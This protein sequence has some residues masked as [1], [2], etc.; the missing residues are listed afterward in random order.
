MVRQRRKGNLQN[1]Q[2]GQDTGRGG[3]GSESS[4]SKKGVTGGY[5]PKSLPFKKGSGAGPSRKRK[6]DLLG[7]AQS[8]PRKSRKFQERAQPPME[9]DEKTLLL[10]QKLP[11]KE[12]MPQLPAQ[13]LSSPK[14]TLHNALQGV[15][16]PK[17]TIELQSSG[18]CKCDVFLHFPEM[19][20]IEA[21]GEGLN[22]KSAEKAAYLHLLCKLNEQNLL[23][24]IWPVDEKVKKDTMNEEKDAK[25]DVYIYAA[26]YGLVPKFSVKSISILRRGHGKV[27]EVTINL[28][29]QGIS[30]VGRSRSE[31]MAEVAASMKFKSAAE[32]YLSES[33]KLSS[34]DEN[35]VLNVG[36]AKSFFLWYKQEFPASKHTV[37]HSQSSRS[38]QQAQF[39]LQGEKIGEP[40]TM[41]SKKLAEEVATLVAAI[42]VTKDSPELRARFFDVFRRSNNQIL[43]PLPPSDMPVSSQTLTKMRATLAEARRSG[44]GDQY[45]DLEVNEDRQGAARTNHR[46][47]SL[48]EIDLR[49]KQLLGYYKRYLAD[50]DLA[51]LRQTRAEYPMNLYIKEVIDIVQ[52]NLYSI[53]IGATGSGKTTQVPQIL[54]NEAIQRGE[55]GK[56]NIVCT[57]PRRIAAKSVAQ[58]VADERAENLTNSVGYHVRRDAKLPRLGGSITYCTTG[59]L[60]QQLQHSPDEIFDSIS[61]LI[62]DEVHERDIII[63][64]LLTTLKNAVAERVEQGKSVPRIVLMSAT[65]DSDM[66]ADYFRI[67]HPTQGFIDCPTLSVPGRTFPVKERHLGEIMES[68]QREHGAKALSTMNLDKDT[69]DY[70]EA[71]TTFARRNPIQTHSGGAPDE[72]EQD[73]IVIDW[74]SERGRALQKRDTAYSETE[75]A[76]VPHSLIATTIAHILKTTQDG[77]ILVFLPGLDNILKV[78]NTIKDHKPLGIN[79]SDESRYR[80]FMLHSSIPDAQK[81]VFNPMPPGCRKIILA[82]NI[83]ETSITIPDVQYVVDV[84][85]LREKQYDQLRR[86]TKLACIWA[87]K[88]NVKQRAGRAGRVQDGHY[89]ALYSKERFESL[90]AVGLPELL[91]SDLQEVCLDIRA[92]GYKVPV[93]RFLAGAIEPPST[94]AVDSALQNL[95][96]LDCLTADETITPLGRLLA[97]LPIHPSLGKMVTLGVIFKCLDPLLIVGAVFN[98]RNLFLNPI[99][100][101]D[102]KAANDSK[103]AYARGTN[104]DH[105]ASLNA[106]K[107]MR[108][109]DQRDG[110]AALSELSRRRYLHVGAY[111]S[112]Q[113][114]AEAIASVLEENQIIHA[115]ASHRRADLQIGD[116]SLNVNSDKVGLI[117]ALILAGAFPNIGA[118][119]RNILYRTLRENNAL[120]HPAS[121]NFQPRTRDRSAQN[122]S[123]EIPLVSYSTLAKSNDGKSTYMRDTTQVSPLMACLFGGHLGLAPNS[124]RVLKMDDWLPFYIQ[125]WDRRAASSIIE[126][127]QG[128]EQM[129]SE[130]FATLY[131]RALLVNNPVREAFAQGLVAILDMDL[132]GDQAKE[133]KWDQILGSW[134]KEQGSTSTESVKDDTRSRGNRSGWGKMM[135]SYKPQD[136]SGA[137]RRIDRYTPAGS[138]LAQHG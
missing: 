24:R 104:S 86:I 13:L 53:V 120:V 65:I 78:A 9:F 101:D 36:N 97:S 64:F 52:N 11:S 25:L 113:G 91:R 56:C 54:L 16:T 60:S 89:Y 96:T 130:A 128:L 7:E 29:E 57:Q 79:F 123:P 107:E 138:R 22:R 95:I 106:F 48:M 82:T 43:Q 35:N 3:Y 99:A 136:R 59:I 112:I 55:G 28:P 118:H 133:S 85:K 15:A 94:E 105:I 132:N 137:A 129:Q 88:S 21:I 63:D 37:E 72:Q 47:L 31:R 51:D 98:E 84:C 40:V 32:K 38:Q 23:N 61:H 66:F 83:A 14:S 39:Y 75:E 108:F 18:V 2:R 124:V 122:V 58:R 131:K 114:T 126:F 19:P 67:K 73:D 30:V 87:S 6:A 74:R 103:I 70:L 121:V 77:A 8:R 80:A 69:R 76:L 109:V 100:R 33:E 110:F 71:E 102:K 41:G 44:L 50:P 1:A 134:R 125:S 49:S 135:D 5:A 119:S 116:P 111:R 46:R 20:M 93:K 127:R 117:K 92:Q 17:S 34:W 10:T 42:H 115:T 68:I 81:D 12:E 4:P 45:D 62:I 27:V 26:K 90:R